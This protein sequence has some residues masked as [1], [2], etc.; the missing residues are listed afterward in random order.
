VGD[1]GVILHTV[2][3]GYSWGRQKSPNVNGL[4]SCFFISETEGWV[5]GEYG[6]I[7][8]T[9]T[10]GGTSIAD[11]SGIRDTLLPLLDNIYPNP[12][13]ESATVTFRL[14]RDMIIALEIFDV[15]GN[16]VTTLFHDM[17]GKG[18]HTA[19][20]RSDELA[21]GVYL[22]RMNSSMGSQTKK[23]VILQ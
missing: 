20:L 5:C 21:A 12:V 11:N 23:F 7:L 2:D 6:T 17:L 3:G 19:L 16:K 22:L 13:L 9:K 4:L 18:I 14:Q 15:L 1:R 10:G 8:Y